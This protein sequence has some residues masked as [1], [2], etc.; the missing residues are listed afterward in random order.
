MAAAAPSA[1]PPRTHVTR[2]L[3]S[4]PLVSSSPRPES[5]RPRESSRGLAARGADALVLELVGTN[6]RLRT[7]PREMTGIGR[8]GIADRLKPAGITTGPR[9]GIAPRLYV[10]RGAVDQR[11]PRATHPPTRG[12]NTCPCGQP[13]FGNGMV[14]GPF[15]VAPLIAA[16]MRAKNPGLAAGIAGAAPRATQRPSIGSSTWPVGQRCGGFFAN[17]PP[18]P[19]TTGGRIAGRVERGPRTAPLGLAKIEGVP[20]TGLPA[21][22]VGVRLTGGRATMTLGPRPNGGRMP[23][24]GIIGAATAGLRPNSD[25]I[26]PLPAGS[27]RTAPGTYTAP[28]F[29]GLTHMP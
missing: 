23:D 29:L 2:S 19:S 11:P 10:P 12:S 5:F 16:P 17:P 28:P 8:L 26:I 21:G 6:E 24:G 9:A 25:G 14:V 4:P 3:D 15:C 1:T 7:G 18:G 22:I 27:V 13:C 20:N